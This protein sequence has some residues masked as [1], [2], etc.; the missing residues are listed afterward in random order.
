[1]KKTNKH[2]NKQKKTAHLIGFWEIDVAISVI[3]QL[4]VERADGF[5]GAPLRFRH[6]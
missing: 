6:R 4:T 1:M 5:Q 2:S 3:I